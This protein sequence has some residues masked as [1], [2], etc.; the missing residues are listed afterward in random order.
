MYRVFRKFLRVF[1]SIAV[2]TQH[3]YILSE[4]GVMKYS[5]C[6]LYACV[7]GFSSQVLAESI[8]RSPIQ[9]E[10]SLT[11][12][13]EKT[14]L[15]LKHD[16]SDG[17]R[18]I[19]WISDEPDL[20]PGYPK[21]MK[22]HYTTSQTSTAYMGTSGINILPYRKQFIVESYHACGEKCETVE[23]IDVFTHIRAHG[24]ARDEQSF[25]VADLLIKRINPKWADIELKYRVKD[26][27]I[28][29]QD[30]TYLENI[31][32]F[33]GEIYTFVFNT[34]QGRYDVTCSYMMP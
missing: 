3:C 12:T 32:F 25:V 19:Q 11:H 16:N 15:Y 4:D 7:F 22:K 13:A 10:G 21:K 5:L 1:L 27:L 28:Y 31:K 20:Y 33:P 34:D 17:Q 2:F 26:P 24:T 18:R 29:T 23:L 30:K 14:V 9:C 8:Q 6:F